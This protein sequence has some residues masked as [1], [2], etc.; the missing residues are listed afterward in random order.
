MNQWA[1]EQELFFSASLIFILDVDECDLGIDNCD[2]MC[3]NN[4]GSYSCRCRSGY[5]L[6][7]DGYGCEGNS[8]T[9]S[10]NEL[11]YN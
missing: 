8:L 10:F 7:G 6:S 1:C 11:I 5:V 4:V 9:N 3:D 2:Q